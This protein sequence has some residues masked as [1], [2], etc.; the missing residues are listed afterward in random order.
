M[1]KRYRRYVLDSGLYV[2]LKDKIAQRPAVQNLI[3]SPVVGM[4]VLRN[5]KP[6]SATYDPKDP[7]RITVWSRSSRIFNGCA[8]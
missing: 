1:C 5:V 2:S 3:G 7:Q 4:R 8:N 6:G